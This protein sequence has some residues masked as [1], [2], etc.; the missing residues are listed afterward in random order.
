VTWLLA[1]AGV[2][3]IAGVLVLWVLPSLLTRQPSAGLS[4]AERLKAV[5]DARGSLITFLVVVGTAGTLF[6]TAA[7]ETILTSTGSSARTAR[8]KARQ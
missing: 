8:A 2:V 6:F 4:T 3:G 1:V 5:N 7:R